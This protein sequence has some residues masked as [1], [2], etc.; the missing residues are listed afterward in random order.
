MTLKYIFAVFTY[1]VWLV[2]IVLLCFFLALG[3]Q[4][5]T[6]YPLLSMTNDEATGFVAT[7][8]LGIVFFG[9]LIY[10]EIRILI[11]ASLAPKQ[12]EFLVKNKAKPT[13]TCASYCLIPYDS[14]KTAH[15]VLLILKWHKKNGV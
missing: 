5:R 8:W 15:L 10:N 14:I 4:A 6:D 13:R 7:W 1:L 2:M 3:L 12:G 9:W 11:I